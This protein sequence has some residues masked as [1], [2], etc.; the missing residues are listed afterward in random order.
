LAVPVLKYSF[1]IINCGQEEEQK[2]DK[3]TLKLLTINGERLTKADVDRLLFPQTVRKGAE[4][5]NRSLHSRNYETGG[6]CRQQE[7]STNADC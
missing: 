6:V 1:G 3:K 2:L 7:R 4:A 5:D